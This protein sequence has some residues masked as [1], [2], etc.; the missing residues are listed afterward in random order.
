MSNSTY[1]LDTIYSLSEAHK[2]PL[3]ENLT[4][5]WVSAM[6]KTNEFSIAANTHY[7]NIISHIDEHKGILE[8]ALNMPYENVTNDIDSFSKY[9]KKTSMD[10]VITHVNLKSGTLTASLSTSFNN[11]QSATD[12]FKTS[13][14][15]AVSAVEDSFTNK[16]TGLIPA[17]EKS[18]TKAKELKEQLEKLP[19]Y[20]GM[21]GIG[22][23]VAPASGGA[24]SSPYG[25]RT[26]PISG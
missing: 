7:G 24:V 13:G 4:T 25:M 11:A 1:A 2:L 21:E 19:K 10:D 15:V 23:A 18:T 14:T 12:V 17:L 8:T 6:Q 22:G 20:T 3:N 5:P 26:H 9:A 16:A